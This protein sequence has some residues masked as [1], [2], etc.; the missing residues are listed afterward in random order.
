VTCLVAVGGW[1]CSTGAVPSDWVGGRGLP[2]AGDWRDGR[3]SLPL[4]PYDLDEVFVTGGEPTIT[5]VVRSERGLEEDVEQYLKVGR[6]VLAVSGPSKSGKTTLVNRVLRGTETPHVRI[7]GASLTTMRD[8]WEIVAHRLA[9]PSQIER[10]SESTVEL[11]AQVASKAGGGVIPAEVSAQI[12][13][14]FASRGATTTSSTIVLSESVRD[15]LVD[16]G[17]CLVID[18]FH[19]AANDV[20]RSLARE[21]KDLIYSGARV[22][23]VAIPARVME[24]L[25]DEGELAGRIMPLAVKDWSKLE[26][27]RI[28]LKGFDALNVHDKGGKLADRLVTQSYGSPLIM[29]ELCAELCRANDASRTQDA[30]TNLDPPPHWESFF[31]EIAKRQRPAVIEHLKLGPVERR[32]R[33]QLPTVNGD[34]VDLYSGVLIALRRRSPKRSVTTAELSETLNEFLQTRPPLSSIRWTCG[35]MGTIALEKRG[36]GD[37]A[38]DYSTDPERLSIV[39]PFLSFFI[40]WGL[41]ELDLPL[42]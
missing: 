41:R 34:P 12:S 40:T 32:K 15:V 1:L 23:L 24:V 42:D 5:Y 38:L 29:Q 39:D 25:Q 3:G 19:Y 13:S 21:I 7:T 16:L 26:L 10:V 20:R 22:I 4:G 28:A 8:F 2:G 31:A 27:L 6:R 9:V 37:A 30:R 17:V 14:R 11:G 33:K 35:K 36:D 18:D